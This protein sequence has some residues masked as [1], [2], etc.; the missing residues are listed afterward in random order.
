MLQTGGC[1]LLSSGCK[2]NLDEHNLYKQ[3]TSSPATWKLMFGWSWTCDFYT[4][5]PVEESNMDKDAA[6]A[7]EEDEGGDCYICSS[8]LFP[9]SIPLCLFLFSPSLSDGFWTR[10]KLCH[11]QLVFVIAP[12]AALIYFLHHE[13]YTIF[14]TLA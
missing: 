8:A 13:L 6:L 1:R 9:F 5:V 2:N 10:A 7:D 11:L 4:Q 14:S 3:Q 12:R